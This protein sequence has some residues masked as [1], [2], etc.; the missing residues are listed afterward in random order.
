MGLIII[1]VI[2][3]IVGI[4]ACW[5]TNKNDYDG[6]N[7][8][9]GIITFIS[10]VI[11]F[12]MVISLLTIK[13]DFKK[14]MLDYKALKELVEYQRKNDTSSLERASIA[15]KMIE[16][17]NVINSH[18]AYHNSIWIGCWYSKEIANLE[19]IK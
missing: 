10:G 8:A 15:D 2:L 18:R 13:S 6:W 12:G 11:I 5:Y 4:W 17:N 3:F 14:N 1:F 19:Y 9:S 7:A 16:N